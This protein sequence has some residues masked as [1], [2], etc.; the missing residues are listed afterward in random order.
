M[1]VHCARDACGHYTDLPDAMWIVIR[2]L[3]WNAFVEEIVAC[4]PRCAVLLLEA[5]HKPSE[6]LIP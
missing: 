1:I 2:P 4:S 5:E 3:M 6:G